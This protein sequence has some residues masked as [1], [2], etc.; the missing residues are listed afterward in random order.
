MIIPYIVVFL[1]IL[2][3]FFPPIRQYKTEYFL[4]F[5]ILALADPVMQLLIK[6]LSFPVTRT[7]L[8]ITYLLILSLIDRN[9]LKKNWII[10]LLFFSVLLALA[11]NLSL[12][13]VYRVKIV[14]SSIILF[15]ILKDSLLYFNKKQTINLFY[16]VL[17]FYEITIIIKFIFV[18]SRTHAGIVY[19]YTTSFFEIFIGLFFCFFN[20]KNSPNF[21][22]MKEST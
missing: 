20:K 14:L 10:V 18:A 11:L 21:K 1:S 7:N 16:L 22:L 4:F 9:K 12:E 13:E 5:L 2:I 6:L 8:I 17:I 15:I 3:W 19:F